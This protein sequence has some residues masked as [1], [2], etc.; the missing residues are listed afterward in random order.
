[1]ILFFNYIRFLAQMEN[2]ARIVSYAYQYN[3]NINKRHHLGDVF[4]SVRYAATREICT[5]DDQE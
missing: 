4:A 5:F 3:I 1:M 2:R